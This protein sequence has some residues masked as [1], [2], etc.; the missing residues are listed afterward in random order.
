MPNGNLAGGTTIA[1]SQGRSLKR[2]WL[3]S[4]ASSLEHRE[5]GCVHLVWLSVGQRPRATLITQVSVTSV[6]CCCP[7]ERQRDG[8]TLHNIEVTGRSLGSSE[9]PWGSVTVG[10]QVQ[11]LLL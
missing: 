10:F 11:V 9:W 5:K 2:E 4:L 7:V 6:L 1:Q 3:G 8:Q